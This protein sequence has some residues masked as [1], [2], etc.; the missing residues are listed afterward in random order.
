M[1]ANQCFQNAYHLAF[2]SNDLTY[3]EGWGDPGRDGL[4]L[5]AW[6]VNEQGKV[7][8]PTWHRDSGYE[9]ASYLGVRFPLSL[10]EAS[11]TANDYYGV[12]CVWPTQYE[13]LRRPYDAKELEQR[14]WRMAR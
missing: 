8:D 12:F 3:C 13:I 4:F 10:V 7:V 5:H 14:L 6:C 9:P 1:P 2:A 11:I